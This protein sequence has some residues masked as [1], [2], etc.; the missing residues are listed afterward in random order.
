MKPLDTS[1]MRDSCKNWPINGSS[2]QVH[3]TME[4]VMFRLQPRKLVIAASV[5]AI[6]AASAAN[7][8]NYSNPTAPRTPADSSSDSTTPPP[9]TYERAAKD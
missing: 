9:G 2:F 3:V 6:L 7:C 8:S 4:H 1:K 5:A